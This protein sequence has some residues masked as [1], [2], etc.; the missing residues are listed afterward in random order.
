MRFTGERELATSV[1]QVWEALHDPEVLRAAIPGCEELVPL[2]AGRFAA[3]LAVRVGPV[4]DSYRGSFDIE[5]VRDGEALVVRIEGKGRFGRLAVDLR[6]DLVEAGGGSF[7]RYDAR[8]S[9]SGFVARVGTP[10][11]AVV[12]GHLT[13]VFFRDLDRSLR[14][15]GTRRRVAALV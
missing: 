8:A 9:V 10:T 6:V 14:T 5:D 13:G 7:L 4:A 12:G 1:E 3:R 2:G 15:G 11:M